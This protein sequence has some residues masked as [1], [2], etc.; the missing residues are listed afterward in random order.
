M[1]SYNQ[2]LIFKSLPPKSSGPYRYSTLLALTLGLT[3]A[4]CASVNNKTAQTVPSSSAGST[5]GTG[6]TKQTAAATPV[7]PPFTG[8]GYYKDDGPG[9][10]PP[11]NLGDIPDAVPREEPIHRYANDPYKVMG[12]QYFPIANKSDY[13]TRGLASWYGR[14]FHGKATATGE[15]YDMYAMTAAHATLPLPSYAR[16]TNLENG[17]SIVVRVNDRGPFHSGRIID[18]SYTAAYKLDILK[19][20]TQ[21]EVESIRPGDAPTILTTD[22]APGP[23]DTATLTDPPAAA[24]KVDPVAKVE[25]KP[26]PTALSAGAAVYL[27]LGAFG[28]PASADNLI[29]RANSLQT[30][31][32]SADLPKVTRVESA[33]LHKVQAGPF[34]TPESADRTAQLIQQNLGIKA[35]KVYSAA[36]PEIYQR[37]YLQLAAVSSVEAAQALSVRVKNRFGAEL[38]GLDQISANKLFKVQAGPFATPEAAERVAMAYQQDF[39]VK[40]YRISR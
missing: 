18:L 13:K 25:A 35:F 29:A 2:T 34:A 22:A 6:G 8:G 17:K 21:V 38:P 28:N 30:T 3:L 31:V 12:R 9:A 36:A 23:L 24:V 15:I 5:S 27:Q 4:G 33:G 39:G 37:I 32:Q 1:N 14:K 10:N 40:P 26:S 19:G 7:T 16:V 11:P 20:V